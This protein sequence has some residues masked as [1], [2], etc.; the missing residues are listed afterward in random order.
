M[1]PAD[2]SRLIYIGVNISNPNDVCLALAADDPRKTLNDPDHQFYS[3][4]HWIWTVSRDDV[5]QTHRVVKIEGRP[6]ILFDWNRDF[7]QGLVT[8]INRLIELRMMNQS[9][10]SATFQLEMPL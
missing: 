2:E 5:L 9:R 6:Y 8:T 1:W 3:I 10:V 7:D 4:L